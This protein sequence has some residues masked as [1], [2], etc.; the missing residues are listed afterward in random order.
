MKSLEP[1]RTSL[2]I[3]PSLLPQVEL[4]NDGPVTV[5]LV[6]NPETSKSPETSTPS[7]TPKSTAT[8]K[9]TTET[10]KPA[11]TAKTSA[12]SAES[13]ETILAQQPYLGGLLG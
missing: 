2:G 1:H 6:S 3:L 13:L 12:E 8:P 10:V 11:K 9:G 7:A 4:C 5:E